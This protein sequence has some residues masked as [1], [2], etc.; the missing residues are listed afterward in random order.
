MKRDPSD[1]VY[2]DVAY[3]RTFKGEGLNGDAVITLSLYKGHVLLSVPS[4]TKHARAM[5]KHTGL[6]LS[7]NAWLRDTDFDGLIKLLREA[8]KVWT[9]HR[10]DVRRV[11]ACKD[12]SKRFGA[13][14]ERHRQLFKQYDKPKKSRGLR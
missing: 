6:H 14:C 5:A 11:A 7:G 10:N 8:K 2:L 1:D 3:E 4:C 9:R 13:T 12:C